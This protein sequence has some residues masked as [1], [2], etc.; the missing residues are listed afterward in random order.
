MLTVPIKSQVLSLPNSNV[1]FTFFFPDDGLTERR[2]QRPQVLS[3]RVSSLRNRFVEEP[4]T[5]TEREEDFTENDYSSFD[6]DFGSRTGSPGDH[7]LFA[8]QK[9]QEELYAAILYLI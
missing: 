6:E 3:N 9:V 1:V 5:T 4:V 8:L 2:F 7:Q